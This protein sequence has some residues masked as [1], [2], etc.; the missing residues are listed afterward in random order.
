MILANVPHLSIYSVTQDRN[1][2]I[3]LKPPSS[4][5]PLT[6]PLPSMYPATPLARD[7]RLLLAS[8][9]CLHSPTHSL[10]SPLILCFVLFQWISMLLKKNCPSCLSCNDLM[11][12]VWIKIYT[13]SQSNHLAA[14]GPSSSPFA[15]LLSVSI[16]H[17]SPVVPLPVNSSATPPV[18]SAGRL[19]SASRALRVLLHLLGHTP[20]P[21]TLSLVNSCLFFRWD[22]S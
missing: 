5:A 18:T 10:L 2:R 4:P 11:L 3:F 12:C 16:P 22:H 13:D 1:W 7:P 6:S 20:P 15:S 14:A 21:H 19:P 9:P 17:P 8:L